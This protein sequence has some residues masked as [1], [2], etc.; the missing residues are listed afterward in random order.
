MPQPAAN[1]LRE[2]LSHIFSPEMFP[3][4]LHFWLVVNFELVCYLLNC[5]YQSNRF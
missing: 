4:L 2:E 1:I 5:G 3:K